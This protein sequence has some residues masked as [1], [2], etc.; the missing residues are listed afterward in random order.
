MQDYKIVIISGPSGSGKSSLCKE[1]VKQFPN[2]YFSV[3]F[4]TRDRRYGEIDGIHYNFI[5]IDDFK[6]GID[7]GVFL[8]YAIVH[9]NYY[10]THKNKVIDAINN[11]MIILFDIDVQGKIAIEKYYPD[12]VSIFIATPSENILESRLK[13]RDTDNSN[14][15]KSRIQ[16]AK[17]ELNYIDL[18]DFVIINDDFN[19]SLEGIVNIIKILD[20]KNRNFITNKILKNWVSN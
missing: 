10:G 16:N 4:T 1:L 3:S 8:E 7:E 15:I 2:I 17:K 13:S 19:N 9:D 6:K 12:A 18:F 14:I 11:N 20:F 5:S